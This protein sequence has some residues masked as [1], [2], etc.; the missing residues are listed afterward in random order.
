MFE[1][2]EFDDFDKFSKIKEEVQCR[3]AIGKKLPDF[4]L[5]ENSSEGMVID[6]ICITLS[7]H[8]LAN[9][10]LCILIYVVDQMSKLFNCLPI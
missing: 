3:H 10:L 5:E 1:L 4:L 6:F 2:K 9:I 7:L 8:I